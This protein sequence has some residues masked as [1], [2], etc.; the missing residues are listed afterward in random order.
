MKFFT[1]VIAFLL[2]AVARSMDLE[3]LL[4]KEVHLFS[5]PTQEPTAEP[6]LSPTRMPTASPTAIDLID[7]TAGHVSR[8]FLYI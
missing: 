3:A 6:T 5:T 8:C 1:T 2:A 7:F 4:S